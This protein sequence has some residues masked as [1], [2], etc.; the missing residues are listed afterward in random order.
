MQN[1]HD[2]NLTHGHNVKI[3]DVP[4]SSSDASSTMAR[5]DLNTTSGDTNYQASYDRPAHRSN[6]MA[7]IIGGLIIALGLLAFLV[8]GGTDNGPGATGSTTA[9]DSMETGARGPTPNAGATGAQRTPTAPAT[10]AP[11]TRGP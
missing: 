4:S 5:S 6:A 10:P 3:T 11:G 7:Y 2:P 8:Y 1:D 9:R